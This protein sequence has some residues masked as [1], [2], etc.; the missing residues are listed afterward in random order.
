MTRS[1][2]PGAIAKRVSDLSTSMAAF[3]ELQLLAAQAWLAAGDA[4]RARAFARDLLDNTGADDVLRMQ[5]HDLLEAAGESSSAIVVTAAPVPP[6]SREQAPVAAIQPQ[7]IVSVAPR[8]PLAS[9]VP[10][11]RSPEV[12][13]SPEMA[14]PR[15]PLAPSGTGSPVAPSM[16]APSQPRTSTRPGFP[17]APARPSAAMRTLPPGTSLPPYRLEARGERVWSTPPPR[18]VDVE[19]LETLS[20]P[21]GM[22]GDEPPPLDE[23]PR[24][25]PAARLTCTFL[26]R[27]LGRELRARYA[28]EVRSDV[29]GLETAQRYLREEFVDGRVRT[30]EEL[31]EV[32]RQGGF[33]GELLARRLGARWVDLESPEPGRWAMLVPSRSRT[34]EVARVWPFA[35]VLRFVAMGHKERDLVSYYLELEGRAR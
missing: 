17:A 27:E 14:I 19:R 24:T 30:A 22:R 9:D 31:R 6:V 11:P 7:A 15:P 4:R 32:M 33:L 13:A 12:Q 16:P 18:D 29:D 34:D 5:A 25:G 1:E 35:R 26:A 21:A 10:T 20:L 8:P 23:H 28:V 2:D 3:H